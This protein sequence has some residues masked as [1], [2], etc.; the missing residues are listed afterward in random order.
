MAKL[1]KPHEM[2]ALRAHFKELDVDNSG[3]ITFE[4]L[5]RGLKSNNTSFADEELAQLLEVC[6]RA[7][8]CEARPKCSM[9]LL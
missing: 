9:K 7:M 1:V 2:E 3:Y 4:E 5:Q 8:L 6:A